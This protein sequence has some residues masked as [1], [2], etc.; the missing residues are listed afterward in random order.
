MCNWFIHFFRESLPLFPCQTITSYNVN[1]FVNE[2]IKLL[3]HATSSSVGF[4][5]TGFLF[6]K[7]HRKAVV[8][9]SLSQK[10]IRAQVDFA[11]FLRTVSFK[12][13]HIVEKE[14][15]LSLLLVLLKVTQCFLRWNNLFGKVCFSLKLLNLVFF[16]MD[17]SIS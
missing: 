9:D 12:E 5:K 3:K 15:L 7:I 8:L 2:Q 1:D 16:V 6:R 11:K 14:N 13:H 10:K 17:I 4:I